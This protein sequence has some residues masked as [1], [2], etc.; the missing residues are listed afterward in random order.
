MRTLERAVAQVANEPAETPSL[1]HTAGLYDRLVAEH[2]KIV[3]GGGSDTVDFAA[4]MAGQARTPLEENDCAWCSTSSLG[5]ERREKLDGTRFDVESALG[6]DAAYL[7]L[8]FPATFRQ[9][10]VM[11][12][13]FIDGRL[14]QSE[15]FGPDKLWPDEPPVPPKD[16]S[17]SIVVPIP[18]EKRAS[19]FVLEAVWDNKLMMMRRVTSSEMVGPDK[20]DINGSL[21]TVSQARIQGWVV[22]R[23]SRPRELPVSITIDD[24][25]SIV[26]TKNEF[27]FSKQIVRGFSFPIPRRY[28][29]DAPHR[30]ELSHVFVDRKLQRGVFQF[31]GD[32]TGCLIFKTLV[33]GDVLKI[34]VFSARSLTDNSEKAMVRLRRAGRII[35]QGSANMPDDPDFQF[36]EGRN[37]LD[38]KLADID[39]SNMAELSLEVS[40]GTREYRI[41]HL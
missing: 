3:S 9:L 29:D 10:S 25:T 5:R 6:R 38:V 31:V 11:I 39:I 15:F 26:V 8:R 22:D 35:A 18:E 4:E 19:G 17:F 7:D 27:P 30:V 28:L 1:V 32:K 2:K 40:E 36:L 24:E 16:R 13:V 12:D 34:T 33:T 23:R 37:S 14:V 21:Y 41:P 20:M